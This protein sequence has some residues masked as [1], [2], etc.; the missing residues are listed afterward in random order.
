MITHSDIRDAVRGA[1]A[2]AGIRA[3]S[4]IPQRTCGGIAAV[5]VKTEA[6]HIYGER[7]FR[8]ISVE[9]HLADEKDVA[10]MLEECEKVFTSAVSVRGRV[11]TVRDATLKY[12]RGTGVYAFVLEFFDDSAANTYAAH[13][14]MGKLNF[15]R[16]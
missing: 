16:R 1:L 14:Y 4:G 3:I 6:R 5:D 15:V 9:V 10:G 11:L 8:R 13:D 12:E 2:A 7:I